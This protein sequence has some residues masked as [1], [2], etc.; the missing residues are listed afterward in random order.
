[1]L[2]GTLRKN[3][4]NMLHKNGYIFITPRQAPPQVAIYGQ[5][6]GVLANKH[7]LAPQGNAQ[8]VF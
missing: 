5:N 1:M 2:I 3:V 6:Y 7:S 4:G 8:G